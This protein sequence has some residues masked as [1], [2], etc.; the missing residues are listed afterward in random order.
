MYFES[1]GEPIAL[2]R[3]KMYLPLSPSLLLPS[4]ILVASTQFSPAARMATRF[5]TYLVY[6]SSVL[7]SQKTTQCSGRS[8]LLNA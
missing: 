1:S 2:Q 8:G 7:E 5:L 3:I 6:R 4:S